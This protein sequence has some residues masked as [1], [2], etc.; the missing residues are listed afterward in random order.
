[1]P[2]PDERLRAISDPKARG[3][4]RV[5]EV[6]K[7]HRIAELSWVGT[8]GWTFVLDAPPDAHLSPKDTQR[9]AVRFD[10]TVRD[11]AKIIFRD[12]ILAWDGTPVM[13]PDGTKRQTVGE[14][15]ETVSLDN[16]REDVVQG[17]RLD[18]EHTVR[19]VTKDGKEP[20]VQVIP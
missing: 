8:N 15:G 17:A 19:L 13:V 3:R 6:V 9:A 14:L 5:A 2:T 7:A 18:I 4:L 10:L 11:G 20:H 12:R 16:F 1:M